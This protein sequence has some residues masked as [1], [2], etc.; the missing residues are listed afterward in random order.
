MEQNITKLP[1]HISQIAAALERAVA[2]IDPRFYYGMAHGGS[3][4]IAT[5]LFGHRSDEG[6]DYVVSVRHSVDPFVPK[7]PKFVQWKQLHIQFHEYE[8]G[9]NIKRHTPHVLWPDAS[10]DIQH[11]EGEVPNKHLYSVQDVAEIMALFMVCGQQH[12]HLER[13]REELT[14][15]SSG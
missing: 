14:G 6:M 12:Q 13:Y 11:E 9:K 2:D 5:T 15:N 8:N 7:S 1:T 3:G 10:W 4:G